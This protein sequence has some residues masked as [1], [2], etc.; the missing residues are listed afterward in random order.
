MND[1]LGI[2]FSCY[3][4]VLGSFVNFFYDGFGVNY[5]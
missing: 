4:F 3:L 2:T 5:S 1:L